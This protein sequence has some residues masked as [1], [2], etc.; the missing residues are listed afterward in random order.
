MDTNRVYKKNREMSKFFYW[1]GIALVITSCGKDID[2]F[3]PRSNQGEIGDV[4]KLTT[5]LAEDIAGEISYIVTVPCDGD[6]VFQIDKDLVV[7]IPRDFVDLNQYPCLDGS[8][9]IHITAC[10]TKGEIMVAGIPTLSEGKLLESRIEVNLQIYSGSTLVKLAHGK[11]ISIKVSDPDPRERMELFYG[12]DDNTEWLQADN[13]PNAWDNVQNA[14]WFFQDSQ[15]VIAGF[16]YSCFSDSTD[17]INVDVFFEIPQEQRTDVCVELPD[18]F[19]NKN[20]AVFMVFDDYKSIVSLYG[21]ADAEKFCE[22]Y[23]S[24]PL[25]F[26]VTFIVISEMGDDLYLFAK[27]STSITSH[28]VE[29]ITPVKTPYEEIKNYILEL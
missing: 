14:E 29:Y 16:G 7:V 22:P 4:K 10:D 8:F 20:T 27:K 9:D 24:T 1:I 2:L 12:N 21:N 5:R 11:Q 15:N 17:W 13:D 6:K 3:I 25:G 26:K 23:A 28:H 18:E 19:T